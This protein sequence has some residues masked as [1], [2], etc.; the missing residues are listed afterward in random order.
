[1]GQWDTLSR[2]APRDR[3]VMTPE[4]Q[5]ALAELSLALPNGYYLAGGVG[6]AV[7]FGH[8]ESHDLDIFVA[9]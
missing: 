5:R 4:Q 1:V 3:Y 8:R 2:K 7:H 9:P 6:L